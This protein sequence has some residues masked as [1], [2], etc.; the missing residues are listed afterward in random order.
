MATAEWNSASAS[1]VQSVA[2]W[3]ALRR[4]ILRL[5]F[6]FRP[7]RAGASVRRL[8]GHDDDDAVWDDANAH[9]LIPG[10]VVS[11][12]A[13]PPS[14][15]RNGYIA[16][17]TRGISVVF[18]AGNGGF[19]DNS[20]GCQTSAFEFVPVFPASC[21]F[22]ASV[23]STI[24]FAPEAAANFSHGGF[25]GVFSM[26]HYQ[27]VAVA[28]FFKTLHRTSRASSTAAGADTLIS[29]RKAG[30]SGTSTSAPTV[31]VIIALINDRLLATGKPVLGFLNP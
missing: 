8:G 30:T 10:L 28:E 12:A 6:H 19:S 3:V 26:P 27:R 29:P 21:P 20:T 23:G 1:A 25:P 17:G 11:G 16:L 15:I 9:P 24:G 14:K 18:A 31:A 7:P 5:L 22:V 4:Y 2:L 13:P